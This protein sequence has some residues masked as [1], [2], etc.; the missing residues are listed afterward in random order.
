MAFRVSDARFDP[1]HQLLS[2]F[3]DVVGLALPKEVAPVEL[4]TEGAPIIL[5]PTLTLVPRLPIE[6]IP[7]ADPISGYFILGVAAVG[8][9][10]A[11]LYYYFSHRNDPKKEPLQVHPMFDPLKK[12]ADRPIILTQPAPAQ[13]PWSFTAMA[14][15]NII[16]RDVQAVENCLELEKKLSDPKVRLLA[17]P[18]EWEDL[19]QELVK[20]RRAAQTAIARLETDVEQGGRFLGG[21]ILQTLVAQADNPFGLILLSPLVLASAK[22]G[23]SAAENLLLDWLERYET[24]SVGNHAANLLAELFASQPNVSAEI[25][26][27][28]RLERTH[29]WA[30]LREI[31]IRTKGKGRDWALQRLFQ[32]R[33]TVE[34]AHVAAR[35]TIKDSQ[36]QV[37]SPLEI[38]TNPKQFW[39]DR[40]WAGTVLAAIRDRLGE[41]TAEHTRLQ[42]I[43]NRVVSDETLMTKQIEAL[44]K[45]MKGAES[46]QRFVTETLLSD[47]ILM[48]EALQEL[49]ESTPRLQQILFEVTTT[50]LNSVAT[51]RAQ[52]F[53]G[54][55]PE[56]ALGEIR[57][58]TAGMRLLTELAIQFSFNFKGL[59]PELIDAA[60]GANLL[61]EIVPLVY[62][63]ALH[64]EEWASDLLME[65]SGEVAKS[66]GREKKL[67]AEA[68]NFLALLLK[69]D[70]LEALRQALEELGNQKRFE[71]LVRFAIDATSIEGA[72]LAID[73]LL[74]HRQIASLFM[75]AGKAQ[76]REIRKEAEEKIRARVFSANPLI[77]GEAITS[78][79]TMLDSM[80]EH[81]GPSELWELAEKIL[82]EAVEKKIP[83]AQLTDFNLGNTT[84]RTLMGDIRID[85]SLDP[86]DP[87]LN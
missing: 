50:A 66:E 5:R 4:P 39:K 49:I 87:E 12:F 40:L 45:E 34:V 79:A 29:R 31:A 22:R 23:N 37:V 24:K 15:A 68:V 74:A 36:K 16:E 59:W 54:C 69:T 71:V 60:Q 80:Q 83:E 58:A 38:L 67:H 77:R 81:G 9:I 64:G 33:R 13:P 21:R 11:G 84:G 72:R 48:Q 2:K 61:P 43:I 78:L 41:K 7:P 51:D 27:L 86:N 3:L 28:N 65:W 55:E 42:Q 35:L 75:I 30:A 26:F 47:G 56:D 46:I 14:S 20:A 82:K 18:K 44:R 70:D 32:N 76:K 17:T 53:K 63:M 19:Q 85:D 10:G 62:S 25:V 6:V 73:L 1:T 57:I 8:I 52:R